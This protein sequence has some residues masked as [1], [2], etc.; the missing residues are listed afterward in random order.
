MMQV[1][2]MTYYIPCASHL[3]LDLRQKNETKLPTWMAR[4]ERPTRFPGIYPH[5]NS[6]I[7]T[8]PRG[9]NLLGGAQQELVKTL[10]YLLPSLLRLKKKAQQLLILAPNTELAGQIFWRVKRGQRLS[11]WLLNSSYQAQVRNARLNALKGPEI[12]IGTPGRIF[13]LIKLKKSRD[14]ECGNHH[15]GWIWPI[16][17]WFSDSLCRENHHYAPRDHQLIYMSATTKFDQENVA[18]NTRTIDLSG[19]RLDNI[20]HF[21]MQVDQRHQW[22]CYEN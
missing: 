6:T 10:A 17:R 18:P 4:T 16:A 22:T 11:A 19:Q 7:W 14:D 21:Y 9:E 2:F 8:H 20:Q 15:P 12:L 13:E 3:A 1:L 5:S